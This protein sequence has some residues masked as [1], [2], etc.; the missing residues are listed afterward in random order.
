MGVPIEMEQIFNAYKKIEGNYDVKYEYNYKRN[1]LPIESRFFIS[2]EG[3]LNPD[4]DVLREWANATRSLL[5][6]AKNLNSDY[7]ILAGRSSEVTERSINAVN[8]QDEKIPFLILGEIENDR[9]YKDTAS[10]LMTDEDFFVDYQSWGHKYISAHEKRRDF[11]LTLF[12]ADQKLP[13]HIVVLDELI[14]GGSK[15]RFIKQFLHEQGINADFGAIV[16]P[17]ETSLAKLGSTNPNLYKF[18]GNLVRALVGIRNRSSLGEKGMGNEA[19]QQA[20][21]VER[22]IDN[23][24]VCLNGLSVK[25][26]SISQIP[27]RL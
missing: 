10:S 5:S 2:L 12:A 6:W 11:L 1:T 22:L 19:D 14:Y 25:K 4:Q 24:F 26:M 21:Q 17:L 3:L 8:N 16:G 15:A 7:V 13:R 18:I 20:L 23:L 9:L 27:P